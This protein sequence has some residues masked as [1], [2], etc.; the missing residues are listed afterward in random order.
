M[1]NVGIKKI[2]NVLICSENRSHRGVVQI[3]NERY[4]L[5]NGTPVN[6]KSNYV[7]V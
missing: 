7:S 6:C 3:I 4:P 2:E 5:E 1:N